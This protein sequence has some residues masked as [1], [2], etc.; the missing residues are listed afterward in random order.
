MHRRSFCKSAA[1][2]IAVGTTAITPPVFAE[3]RQIRVVDPGGAATEAFEAAYI[4]PF[5][6]KTGI[7]VVV[8]SPNPLGK[9]R[10]LV[11]S[12]SSTTTMYVLGA[13]AMQ[14]AKALGLIQKLDWGKIAPLPMFPETRDDYGM[15]TIFYS[16][17]M[18]WRK[19]MKAPANWT[20]FF[21]SKAF[22]GKRTLPDNPVYVLGAVLLASGVAMDKLYPLDLDRAFRQ[23]DGI[24]KDVAVWWKAG[25]QPLQLLRDNEVQYAISYSG[26]VTGQEGVEFSFN[27]ASLD[28][29]YLCVVKGANSAD[30]DAA[31]K[32]LYEVSDPKNQLVNFGLSPYPGNSPELERLLPTSSLAGLPTAAANK[33]LQFIHDASWWYDHADAVQKR[34][35]E[36]TLGL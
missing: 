27:Q 31:Y 2:T 26:P 30:V 19:G 18:A 23:L 6:S 25:S 16:T 10:A 13:M 24:K 9:L 29:S 28:V 3:V 15:G 22:P 32:L 7:K 14:Q 11:E 12:G 20:D 36:F 5:T 33:K 17:L 1:A 4:K 35:Q 21:D 8:E 34:W